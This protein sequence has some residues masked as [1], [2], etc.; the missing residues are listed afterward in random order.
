[1][2]VESVSSSDSEETEWEEYEV[3]IGEP[4]EDA[5]L[6]PM[7][8]LAAGRIQGQEFRRPL[9][10]L[11]DSGST[12]AWINKKCLPPGA[13]GETVES[14]TGSTIAGTSVFTRSLSS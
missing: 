13:H 1:M 14:V 3:N 9:V 8:F 10:A 2:E 4:K 7:T 11:L 5:D 12:A 6:L